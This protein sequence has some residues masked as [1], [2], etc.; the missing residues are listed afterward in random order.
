M[1]KRNYRLQDIH[2]YLLEYYHLD[3]KL[4]LVVDNGLERRVKQKDFDINDPSRLM[5]QAVVSDGCKRR[6]LP[7]NVSNNNL[8][9][10]YGLN[11]PN[12]MWWPDYVALKYHEEQILQEI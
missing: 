1:A 10:G 7:L 6:V 4:F 3:W 12:I 8:T 11:E 9:I 2:D 5:V